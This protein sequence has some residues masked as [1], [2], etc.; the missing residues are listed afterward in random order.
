MSA[1][2]VGL[3]IG[4]L[5][6]LLLEIF[7]IPGF[8]VAGV[9]GGGSV[10]AG[11]VVA[12]KYLGAVYG[13]LAIVAGVGSTALLLY[14][15]PRKQL[16]LDAKQA[17]AGA[18]PPRLAELLGQTGTSVT[19]LRPAGT[20]EIGGESVDV[21]TGGEYVDSGRV[22]RVVRVEGARVVVEPIR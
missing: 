18:A 11:I 15:L 6:L 19:P 17:G 2:V 1:L 16:I 9:V 20:V 3:V 5:L 8:G 7:V 21:V 13:G 14:F 22:V 10:I 12:W 4:G